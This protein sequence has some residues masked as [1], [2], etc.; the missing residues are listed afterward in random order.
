MDKLSAEQFAAAEGLQDWRVVGWQACTVFRT[1]D[2]ATGLRLVDEIGRLAEE[3]DHHPDL[4][5]R[6]PLLEVR[7]ATHSE[8]A[9]TD[10]DVTLARQVS[11]AAEALGVAADP[12]AVAGSEVARTAD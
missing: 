5:L 3:A 11:A 8:S 2:F 4:N 10:K 9:L 7:L 6:Y 1:G 12:D